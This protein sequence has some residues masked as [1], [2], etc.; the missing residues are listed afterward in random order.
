[1]GEPHVAKRNGCLAVLL[2]HLL[3]GCWVRPCAEGEALF[4]LQNSAQKAPFFPGFSS[5][6]TNGSNFHGAAS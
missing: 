6:D 2:L 1:M 5:L 4:W 3:N